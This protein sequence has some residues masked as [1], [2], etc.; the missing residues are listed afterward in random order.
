MGFDDHKALLFKVNLRW[1]PGQKYLSYPR[2]KLRILS[3]WPTFSVLYEKALG[4]KED[5]VQFDKFVLRMRDSYIDTKTY[6]FSTINL[7]YGHFFSNGRVE[8][9]DYFHFLSNETT[10]AYFDR[11]V[12]TFKNM[13]FY[14]FS[15]VD[16]FVM[17]NYEQHFDGYIMDRIPFLQ[18]S[19][20]TLVAGFGAL[21]S[22]GADYY[23]WNVGIEGFSLGGLEFLRFDFVQSYT[24]SGFLDRGVKI[25]L[26][27]F[28]N[29]VVD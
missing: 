11:Y 28:F 21:W 24:D 5:Y 1:R 27:R 22:K 13:P 23:E 7:E 15:T 2:F 17:V 25:G 6:G 16:D 3:E 29:Q 26:T 4:N 9:M 10:T 12:F 8:L 19:G 20:L 14:D 18:D